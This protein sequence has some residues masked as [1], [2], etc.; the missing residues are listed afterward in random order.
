[1]KR[2]FSLSIISIFLFL[3]SSC[4][5]I[6]QDNKTTTTQRVIDKKVTD[7]VNF[8]S[9]NDTHG[10]LVS[11]MNGSNALLSISELDAAIN[12]IE[13][14]SGK[15]FIRIMNGDLFQGSYV[16]RMTYGL[17]L[18][19][20][21][22]AADFD[23]MVLGN[24]EFDWGLDVISQY[25]DGDETNGEADFPML[26]A[27][28]IDK[29]TNARPSWIK[30][31]E[32]FD[33]DGV[34]VG[35]IGAIGEDLESTVSAQYIENYEFTE[36]IPTVKKYAKELR[37]EKNCDIVV[38]SCHGY[39][40]DKFKEITNSLTSDIYIDAY[41]AGHTHQS[42]NEYYKREDGYKIPLIQ[43]YAK[44]GNF[45]T[46]TLNIN[47][48][49]QAVS[50]SLAHYNMSSNCVSYTTP[51]EDVEE[52]IKKYQSIIDKGE[53]VVYTLTEPLEGKQMVGDIM[54]ESMIDKTKATIGML[55]TG[56]I[57]VSYVDAG[58]VKISDVFEWFP[59]DNYV[60][61]V[62]MTGAKLKEYYLSKKSGMVFNSDF[63]YS[64]IEDDKVYILTTSDYCAS[65]K[66]EEIK[67]YSTDGIIHNTGIIMY[68]MLIEYLE[69]QSN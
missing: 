45:G 5:V 63:D 52:V 16:S 32:I 42:I 24:H 7:T 9:I 61:Y 17:C 22:N 68:D 14:N 51:T 56:G 15:D 43:S 38:Y 26:C 31:Y 46:I 35:I 54:M 37:E 59:F 29:R 57:R 13:D 47:K 21:L 3:L 53:S 19:E 40:A 8:I 6:S 1:M 2:L 25:F 10:Q 36:E 30:P 23:C 62:N 44:N 27:N 39:N 11:G 66:N 60:V 28:I 50:G 55:N 58:D 64:S 20:A 41:F 12:Y 33:Y 34:T 67:E 69:N 49:K 4:A 65:Y 18:I 48:D